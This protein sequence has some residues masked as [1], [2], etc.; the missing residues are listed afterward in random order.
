MSSGGARPGS[1]RKK[2]G[3]QGSRVEFTNEQLQELLSS[4]HVAFVSRKTIS[5]TLA[6]NELFWQRYVDGIDP[7]QKYGLRCLIRHANPYR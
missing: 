1:E 5:Y 6:F 4:P 2:K 3:E 7:M